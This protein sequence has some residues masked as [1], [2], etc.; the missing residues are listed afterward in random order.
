MRPP[1]TLED[2]AALECA[3]TALR[4]RTPGRID[5][6]YTSDRGFYSGNGYILIL[7]DGRS[8][9]RSWSL[10]DLDFDVGDAE[11]GELEDAAVFDACLAETDDIMRFDCMRSALASVTAV[12]NEGWTG[13]KA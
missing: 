6:D 9:R 3:L 11:L 8:V 13:S 1:F 5:W 4:D 10:Y 2:P 7:E 12:C